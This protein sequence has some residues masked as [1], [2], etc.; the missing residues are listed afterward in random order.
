[1][2]K[3]TYFIGIGGIGMS[4]LARILLQKGHTVFGSDLKNSSI[5]DSLKKQGA[6]V[7][8]EQKNNPIPQTAEVIYST[9]IDASHSERCIAQKQGNHLRHRAALLKELMDEKQPLTVSGTHGKTTTSSLLAWTL[10]FC[11]FNP[12][13]A[14]GGLLLDDHKNSAHGSGDYFVAEADESDGT[15]T[16]YQSFGA[17]LTNIECDHMDYFKT[18]ETLIEKFH[19]YAKNVSSKEHFFYCDEDENIKAMDLQGISYGFS[20]TCQLKASQI[21]FQGFSSFFTVYFKEQTYPNIEI[22]LSGHHNVL[23]ALAVFGLALQLGI[24]AHSITKAFKHFPGIK[25][26]MEILGNKQNIMLIDDYAHFPT[27]ISCTLKALRSSVQERA[28]TAI[29]QPHRYTRTQQCFNEFTD[30]FKEADHVIITDIYEAGEP[31]ID[32]ISGASLAKSLPQNTIYVPFHQLQE[33]LLTHAKCHDVI[34]TLGAGSITSIGRAFNETLNNEQLAPMKLG[35]VIGGHSLEHNI[36]LLSYQNMNEEGGFNKYDVSLFTIDKEGKIPDNF[37][38]SLQQC[39]VLFPLMHGP[40]GEDGTIQGLFEMIQKPYIGPSQRACACAMDKILTKQIAQAHD[41]Q[42]APYTGLTNKEWHHDKE[43]LLDQICQKHNFPCFVKAAHL[44]STF[45]VHC[46]NNK[47]DLKVCIE[48][49]FLHDQTV[50][51]ED[52]IIGREIEVAVLGDLTP[53]AL[54]PGEVLSQGDI[55]D[56]S[57]KYSYEGITS[58][59]KADLSYQQRDMIEKVAIKAYKVTQCSGMARVDLFLTEDGPILNEINPIPGLTAF[60]LFPKMCLESGID[61]A[62]LI[63]CLVIS[64]LHK[65]R[66]CHVP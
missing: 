54:H 24:E 62:S 48:K 18:K 20:N 9:A 26:R 56:F 43:M 50:L 60:S 52:K 55:Y 28:I 39:D 66:R 32:G 35:I 3:E 47:K 45:C 7:F 59:P 51:V 41:I 4:G 42:I 58:I 36:S 31:P 49:I 29:F 12:S 2:N 61:A 57:S 19:I 44:G 46:V 40:Y 53:I 27:E 33:H 14:L 11:G 21:S 1:M 10:K 5:I 6:T 8:T 38:Y 17:I 13:Y 30:A 63:D 16:L 22:P 34:I 37:I 65:K 25:R 15:F 64:A 23:N